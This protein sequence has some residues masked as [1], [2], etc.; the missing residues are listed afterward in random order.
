M[1][2]N[3]VDL[4]AAAVH[5]AKVLANTCS[6]EGCHRDRYCRG[7]CTRHYGLWQRYGDPTATWEVRMRQRAERVCTD[8]VDWHPSGCW[9]WTG[10]LDPKGYGTVHVF[11]KSQRAHRVVYELFVGPI[12]DGLEL[13][14]LC[15]VRHCVN[16]DH[17]EPVDHKT[18]VLRGDGWG[19][20]NAR[21]TH[22]VNGHEFT[23]ENTR[24]RIDGSRDCRACARAAFKKP[25]GPNATHGRIS[26]YNRGCRCDEC[27]AVQQARRKKRTEA[28][29]YFEDELRRTHDGN[30][31]GNGGAA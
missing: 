15:R 27:K 31:D 29:R 2:E 24:L 9:L 19:A 1:T 11:G 10:R 25:L 6:I 21:K 12:P 16:P 13:D 20:K 14:H 22:C 18:N 23:D 26:T 3:V 8:L 30:T 4:Q 7:W 5:R 17:L 28:N